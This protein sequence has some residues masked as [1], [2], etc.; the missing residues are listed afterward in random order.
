MIIKMT[1]VA[2]MAYL[3]TSS[4]DEGKGD[5]CRDTAR[6]AAMGTKTDDCGRG[7]AGSD[8]VT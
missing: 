6:V 5:V 4:G 1:M 2:V 8:E 7:V 3:R